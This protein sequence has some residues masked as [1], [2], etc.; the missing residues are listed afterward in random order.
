MKN[1]KLPLVVI[2][3]R[4]NVG[5]ST[6][7]NRLTEKRQALVTPIAGTTRDSNEGVVEWNRKQFNIVDTGGILEPLQLIEDKKKKTKAHDIDQ[8]VQEQSR[9]FLKKADLVLFVVDGIV[10]LSA[11]DKQMASI[12]KKYYKEIAQTK[13]RIL[14]VANKID[15]ARQADKIAS[16]Y[17]LALGEPYA[18]S[19]ATGKGTGDLLEEVL[20]RLGEANPEFNI[21]PER[22]EEPFE[23]EEKEEETEEENEA[24]RKP[25]KKSRGNRD[26]FI[27][28][29]IIGQTNVGKSQLLNAITGEE[30]TIVSPLPH[31][32]REP[33]DTFISHK[34]REIRLVDTAGLNK[35]VKRRFTLKQGDEF[36]QAESMQRS[37]SALHRANIALLVV[38]I[39]QPLVHQD[40]KIMQEIVERQKSVIIIANKWDLV[41]DKDTKKYK[42][43]IYNHVPFARWAPIQFISALTG[44][45]VK[46]IL[47]L[48]LEIDLARHQRVTDD[49]LREFM[50]KIVK[51]H[52]PSKGKGTRYPYIHHIWQAGIDP[53]VFDVRIG[54]R[55]DLHFSYTRFIENRL[56]ENY[57]FIGSPIKINVVKKKAVHGSHNQ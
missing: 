51:I 55:E 45:K 9:S 17:K 28:I 7:F 40:V 22:V 14:L 47:D 23:D 10:G 46:K 52:R 4:A 8:Q 20:L 1:K 16:F 49:E 24:F 12:I 39:S 56:R 42:T 35:N 54:S 2:F 15:S 33:Q 50:K 3:G 43:M 6:L 30:R 37:L 32:T 53:I 44:A 19:A 5:K 38:D 13:G 18:V 36:M 34:G 11:E 26:E 25:T 21:V 29:C 48:C 57:G 27:N 31:T 41:T